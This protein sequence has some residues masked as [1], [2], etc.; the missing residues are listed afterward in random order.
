MQSQWM[1]LQDF[2]TDIYRVLR[3]GKLRGY[4]VIV[5]LS[6]KLIKYIVECEHRMSDVSFS[7]LEN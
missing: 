1:T 5:A 6:M 3:T 7:K 2:P 4:S